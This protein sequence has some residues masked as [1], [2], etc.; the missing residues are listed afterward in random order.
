MPE[1]FIYKALAPWNT[2]KCARESA[3]NNSVLFIG[4]I[5]IIK[6]WS[7]LYQYIPSERLHDQRDAHMTLCMMTLPGLLFVCLT[8][9]L[10]STKFSRRLNDLIF[11]CNA[12]VYTARV[13][14]ILSCAPLQKIKKKSV[15]T[16]YFTPSVL[17]AIPRRGNCVFTAVTWKNAT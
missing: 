16:Y 17:S 4:L 6:S 3:C 13:Y 8:H 14:S 10:K 5:L 15:I 12:F 2:Y 11:E 7:C 1:C 9:H